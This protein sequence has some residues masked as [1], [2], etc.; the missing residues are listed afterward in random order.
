MSNSKWNEERDLSWLILI[1]LVLGG[2][3]GVFNAWRDNRTNTNDEFNH[4][5]GE[6]DYDDE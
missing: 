3:C 1:V 6:N 2:I 5:E 4:S